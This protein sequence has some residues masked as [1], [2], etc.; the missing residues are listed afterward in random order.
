MGPRILQQMELNK[1]VGAAVTPPSRFDL[2]LR[3]PITQ[4]ACAHPAPHRRPACR[5]RAAASKTSRP[6]TRPPRPMVGRGR[7]STSG[8]PTDPQPV[9]MV[10][11]YVAQERQ[12]LTEDGGPRQEKP[13]QGHASTN[14]IR[15]RSTASSMRRTRHGAPRL[16]LV[17]SHAIQTESRTRTSRGNRK[18]EGTENRH[19]GGPSDYIAGVPHPDPEPR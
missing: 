1:A 19:R 3:L 18:L 10:K 12:A 5:F 7:T 17:R 6:S 2:W 15:R 4:V 9:E 14:T 16:L 8:A 11:G 13:D